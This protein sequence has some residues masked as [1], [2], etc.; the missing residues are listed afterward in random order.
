[1]LDQKLNVRKD[2]SNGAILVGPLPPPTIGQSISFEMLRDEFSARSLPYWL[3]DISG[4]ATS[5]R[6]GSFSLGRVIALMASLC[7]VT[8]LPFLRDRNFYLTIAQSWNG[9]LRDLWFIALAKI[10]RHRIVLHLKGGSYDNFYDSLGNFRKAIVRKTLS[11]ADCIIVLGDRLAPMFD[12]VPDSAEKIIVVSNGCPLPL[13]ALPK[14]SK[15][16]P[17]A[18]SNEPINILYLS[19]LIDSKGYRDLLQAIAILKHVHKLNI[20]CRFCGQFLI[21]SD[22]QLFH[23]SDEA[24]ADFKTQSKSLDIEDVVTWDGVVTG[25]RKI[26]ALKEAH[27]MVLPTQYNNEGQPVAIIEAMAMGAVVVG[28]RWRTIPDMLDEGRAGILVDSSSPLQIVDAITD[29]TADP[30]AYNNISQAG[31]KH[32]QVRYSRE[33]HLDEL[34]AAINA[35]SVFAAEGVENRLE[36]A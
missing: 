13:E 17:S 3:L 12:F 26:E 30:E 22:T 2:R 36:S 5:R 21:A 32:C 33:K 1:M 35:D 4:G 19:N 8:I 31:I 18:D 10:G 9:F 20:R 27:F 11:C 14:N 25:E 34:I 23:N 6:D 7:R 16:L 24:E 15:H 28:S 29:A